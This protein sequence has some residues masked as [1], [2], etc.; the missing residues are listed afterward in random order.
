MRTY[1]SLR[2]KMLIQEFHFEIRSGIVF[3]LILI[4]C[5]DFLL[6]GT[7]KMQ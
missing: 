7:Y 3:N 6:F 4:I 2:Y 5:K 1:I